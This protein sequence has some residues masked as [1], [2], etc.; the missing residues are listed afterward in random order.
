MLLMCRKYGISSLI[1]CGF[2]TI[3]PY[4]DGQCCLM[5]IIGVASQDARW[6]M[7]SVSAL[8]ETD[9]SWPGSQI[10]EIL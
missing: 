6:E 1:P 5:L 4:K 10:W 3:L 2:K 7:P 9:R 8:I